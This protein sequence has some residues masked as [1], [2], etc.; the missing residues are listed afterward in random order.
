[1]SN[2]EKSTQSAYKQNKTRPTTQGIMAIVRCNNFQC[3]GLKN[4][5]GTWQDQHGSR[6]D[7]VDVVQEL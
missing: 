3:L 2:D 7:V 5:D 4:A 1:M 6:L